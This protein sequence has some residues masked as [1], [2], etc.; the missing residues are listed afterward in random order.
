MKADR[1]LLH[2]VFE[3]VIIAFAKRAHISLRKSLD[4]FYKSELYT[5]I[6]EGI[7][8]MHCRSDEYLAEELSRE[9]EGY[10]GSGVPH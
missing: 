9:V 10:T 4:L 8:D 6:S 2:Y 3:G 1:V 7:S 5:E